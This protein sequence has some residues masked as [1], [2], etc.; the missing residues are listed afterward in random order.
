VKS[1]LC[2]FGVGVALL[3]ALTGCATAGRGPA[4]KTGTTPPQEDTVKK[5][6]RAAE[7][8]IEETL[9]GRSLTRTAADVA[10]TAGVKTA[11]IE[12][13]SVTGSDIDVDTLNGI[14]YLRG[15]VGSKA[16][17]QKAYALALKTFG[18]KAVKSYLQYPPSGKATSGSAKK[19]APAK[20]RK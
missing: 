5:A 15:T 13:E 2:R 10:L 6:S 20:A 18:V 3:V 17:A 12:D 11:L 16:E 14:V 7:K 1:A 19:K 9:K 4:E 8:K